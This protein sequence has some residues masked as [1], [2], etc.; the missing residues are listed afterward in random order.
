MEQGDELRQT[1]LRIKQLENSISVTRVK[2]HDE[3]TMARSF[4][5]SYHLW[6]LFINSL[7]DQVKL[8]IL[9]DFA[10]KMRHKQWWDSSPFFAFNRGYQMFLRVRAAGNDDGEG[11]HVSV[12]LHL[13]NGPHDDEL[14]QSGHW[15]LR[16]TFYVELLNKFNDNNYY[17]DDK[18]N[19]LKIIRFNNHTDVNAT[20]RVMEGDMAT[21]G[22][23]YPQ[24]VS[25]DDL[26]RYYYRYL[27]DD[28]LHFRV[29]YEHIDLEEALLYLAVVVVIYLSLFYCCTFC[30]I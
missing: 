9:S 22:L 1:R 3:L 4:I 27:K 12:Y 28:T 24:F 8:T 16:G 10:T 7:F 18:Y 30:F 13:M 29:T 15:P 23:G 26:N 2:K 11:T 20:K 25:H 19:H 5:E 17:N 21:V 6:Q 14:K